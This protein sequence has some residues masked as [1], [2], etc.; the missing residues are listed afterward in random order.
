MSSCVH[1]DSSVS[2]RDCKWVSTPF[3]YYALGHAVWIGGDASLAPSAAGKLLF[4]AVPLLEVDG[5]QLVETQAIVRYVGRRRGLVPQDDK[6]H[7][8]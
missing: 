4:S 8:R 3:V 5:L 6:L 7:A 2:H 1:K